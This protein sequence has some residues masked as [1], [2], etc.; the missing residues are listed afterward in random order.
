MSH[1]SSLWK[2]IY[3]IIPDLNYVLY[4]VLLTNKFYLKTENVQIKLNFLA[5]V[6]HKIG[7]WIYGCLIAN[8]NI[9]EIL[10]LW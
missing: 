5:H 7:K 4:K 6:S 10:L 2:V 1:A 8:D 9:K 3:F